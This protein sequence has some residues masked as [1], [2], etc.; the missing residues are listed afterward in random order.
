MYYIDEELRELRDKIQNA[1]YFAYGN[2]MNDARKE[3]YLAILR[4]TEDEIN[5]LLTMIDENK[6]KLKNEVEK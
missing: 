3:I 5:Y 6:T 1:I 2:Y 4:Q